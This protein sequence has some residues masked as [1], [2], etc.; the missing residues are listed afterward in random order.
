MLAESA[1][2]G[3]KSG[4]TFQQLKFFASRHEGFL[5][6]NRKSWY[7]CS[8]EAGCQRVELLPVD[9]L[10]FPRFTPKDE[11]ESIASR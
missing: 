11:A 4:Q 1:R 5:K 2:A 10:V 3:V 6:T 7:P 8:G 9:M